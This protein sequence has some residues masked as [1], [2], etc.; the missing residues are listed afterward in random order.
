MPELNALFLPVA[1]YCRQEVMTCSPQD[2]LVAAVER[3]RQ[4]NISSL[5]VC[6]QE[7]PVGIMTDRDLRN[8]VV[9][10]GRNPLDLTVAE[11]MHSPLITI[12]G[13]E[14][15]FEA[16][17]RISRHRIHRLVV[18]DRSGNL[19]G[20]I[21]DSDILRIQTH[22]PQQLM[23]DIEEAASL[24]ELQTLHL[25]V[26]DLVSHLIS[27]GVRVRDMVRL[28]AHLNDRILV[29]LVDLL[30]VDRFVGLRERCA[31]LVLGSEGRGEQTLTT[32]QDNALVFAD[33]LT[34]AEQQLVTQFSDEL[35]K[36]VITIGIPPC[37]GGIMA[38]NPEWCRSLAD[39]K[40]VL[41]DWFASP[42]PE[43]IMRVSMIA[44]LRALTGN[45]ALERELR[46]YIQGRLFQNET[47]L[48][49]M[50]ANLSR[51]PVP[52]GWFGRF[53]T[54]RGMQKGQLDL[55]KS[56]IFAITEGVRILCLSVG[57][58]AHG[59]QERIE[60]LALQEI[61]SQQEAANL[62]SA[63]DA[64]VYFRLRSQ[65]EARAAGQSPT[66]TIILSRLN[67]MEQERLRSALEEVRSF[68]GMLQR[69][70]RL[71]QMI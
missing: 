35:I 55:K 7:R 67:R 37:P 25:R 8:K 22:S 23:R 56:G 27:T 18:L 48:G 32:D 3:M 60:Q 54:A 5:V 19:T 6:E 40:Q 12:Y 26:Q 66:N 1:N 10:P 29:R 28:I 36:G 45:L 4:L 44:D 69:R 21:T 38:N 43:H 70:F 39:W 14:F 16:L 61:L 63:Y 30:L 15:L 50:T 65:V 59:T 13:D 53:T 34:S 62:G 49:H 41:D 17:H 64:L 42:T 11:I 46:D 57:I 47:Y 68:Q 51:F 58:S 33:N 9:A 71:G 31:F 52:L 24:T 20:I 2:L